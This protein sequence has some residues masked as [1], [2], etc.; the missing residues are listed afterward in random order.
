MTQA[1]AM[2]L[3]GVIYDKFIVQVT[4]T[5]IVN[6]D[7]NMC[8]VQAEATGVYFLTENELN[9]FLSYTVLLW[10]TKILILLKYYF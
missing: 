2:L 5:M 1:K 10:E 8:I 3:R 4:V 6:Y 7:C 9:P